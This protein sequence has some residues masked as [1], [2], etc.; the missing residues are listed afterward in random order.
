MSATQDPWQRMAETLRQTKA[1]NRVSR[2]VEHMGEAAGDMARAATAMA[3]A[4]M[5]YQAALDEAHREGFTVYYVPPPES[6]QDR[7]Q[8]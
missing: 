3:E 4:A 1:M 6:T 5:E 8:P 7:P 2:A